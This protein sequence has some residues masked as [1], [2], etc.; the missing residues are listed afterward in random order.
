MASR[1]RRRA[2]AA[3]M[4]N[5]VAR[6]RC[7]RGSENAR[8]RRVAASLSRAARIRRLTLR[9]LTPYWMARC[10]CFA[11]VANDAASLVRGAVQLR[12]EAS[13]GRLQGV[14]LAAAPGPRVRA[15]RSGLCR[16]W[17]CPA[18]HRHRSRRACPRRATPPD[19]PRAGRPGAAPVRAFGSSWHRS[20][21][22]QSAHA[23]PRCRHDAHP[24]WDETGLL[25]V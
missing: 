9:M 11:P 25:R 13:R 16:R 21:S 22:V 12:R 8:V 3:E 6:S 18:A 24:S 10:F 2:V 19:A 7:R 17:S 23:T 1:L 4:P 20:P 15:R 14:A 5:S